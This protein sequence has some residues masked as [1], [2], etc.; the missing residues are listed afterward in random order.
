MRIHLN[1][2]HDLCSDQYCCWIEQKRIAEKTQKEYWVR[3][4]GYCATVARLFADY[5]NKAFM[6]SEAE[7]IKDLAEDLEKLKEEM[8]TFADELEAIR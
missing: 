4:T 5:A 6:G 2:R 3:V 7:Q 1:E 8:K